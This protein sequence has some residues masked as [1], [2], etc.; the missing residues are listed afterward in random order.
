MN[1][2]LVNFYPEEP[3]LENLNGIVYLKKL[4]LLNY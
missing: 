1:V 4:W 2:P 3:I